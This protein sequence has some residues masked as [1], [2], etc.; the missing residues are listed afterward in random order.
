[1]LLAPVDGIVLGDAH[2]L[3]GTAG[4]RRPLPGV[5]DQVT[6]SGGHIVAVSRGRCVGAVVTDGPLDEF[7]R[8]AVGAD[9]QGLSACIIGET[10]RQAVAWTVA[11]GVI[12]VRGLD[13]PG[14]VTQVAVSGNT[15]WVDQMAC[16]AGRW[17]A[18]ETQGLVTVVD[19]HQRELDWPDSGETALWSVDDLIDDGDSFNGQ[20]GGWWNK[21]LW[22]H[23]ETGDTTA[24]TWSWTPHNGLVEH[25]LLAGRTPAGHGAADSVGADG[26]WAQAGEGTLKLWEPGDTWPDELELGELTDG[27][28]VRQLCHTTTGTVAARSDHWVATVKPL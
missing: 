15:P 9:R 28:D 8:T 14:G 10:G 26:S 12:A 2:G 5:Y 7:T 23:T 19:V 6:S 18:V 22:G 27:E 16:G 3:G 17:L 21:T 11:G 25:T 1:M 24:S 4:R 20:V 13:G